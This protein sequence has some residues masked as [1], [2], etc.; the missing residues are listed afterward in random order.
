MPCISPPRQQPVPP[1]PQ[2]MAISSDS[3][4]P[5]DTGGRLDSVARL[6]PTPSESCR[7]VSRLH[8]QASH[9]LGLIREENRSR[10]GPNPRG[11]E[12]R[13]YEPKTSTQPG[14]A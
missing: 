13:R 9:Q 10:S 6:R 7:A 12:A 3:S 11:D 8:L 5:A 2:E 1:P 14:K 4:E